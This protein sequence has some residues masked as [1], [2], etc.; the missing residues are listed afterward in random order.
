VKDLLA[1]RT[2]LPDAL[3]DRRTHDRMY[4]EGHQEPPTPTPT[5]NLPFG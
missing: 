1:V 5:P 2:K 4:Q 3:I